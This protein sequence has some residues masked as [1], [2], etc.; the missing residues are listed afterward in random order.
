[1]LLIVIASTLLQF[2]AGFMALR[3]IADSG[4]SWAWTL[5]S[6]GIFIMA[7]R[8]CTPCFKFT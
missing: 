8:G 5:L 6:A 2:A 7:F 4:K 1:M 3:L